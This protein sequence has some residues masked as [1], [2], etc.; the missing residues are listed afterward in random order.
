MEGSAPWFHL[1]D[2]YVSD[3][4]LA[5]LRAISAKYPS[6]LSGD[7]AIVVQ[8]GPYSASATGS[9]SGLTLIQEPGKFDITVSGKAPGNLPITLTLVGSF[10]EEIPDTV[11]SRNEVVSDADGK[12]RM[13]ISP[14]PAYYKGAVLTLVASSVPG[15]STAKAQIVLKAPNGGTLIPGD[16]TPR[17]AR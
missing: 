13:D 5:R 2:I 11:I 7:R 6:Q 17:A 4:F 15:V 9:I 8:N 14:A 1:N 3:A 10:S 16:V 12:F